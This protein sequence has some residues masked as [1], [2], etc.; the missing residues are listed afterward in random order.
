MSTGLAPS[1]GR[2]EVVVAAGKTYKLSHSNPGIRQEFSA[3]AEEQALR[4]LEEM[5]RRNPAIFKQRREWLNEQIMAG[6]YEWGFPLDGK[7]KA[8]GSAV[9]RAMGEGDGPT[10]LLQL[11]LR[12]H[13]GDLPIEELEAAWEANPEEFQ[14]KMRI[15]IDPNLASPSQPMPET[16]TQETMTTPTQAAA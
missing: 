6:A 5:R 2:F 13:H 4:R 11:L 8:M 3:W 14:A 15:C 9:S 10:K 16:G 1:P 12:E 7:T